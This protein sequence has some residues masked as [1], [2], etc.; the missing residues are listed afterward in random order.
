MYLRAACILPVHFR[1]KLDGFVEEQSQS[2]AHMTQ[3]Q[4]FTVDVAVYGFLSGALS[5]TAETIFKRTGMLP[6]TLG[7][8]ASPGP[9][10]R[11]AGARCAPPFAAAR[12]LL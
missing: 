8:L 11:R 7:G 4:V 12:L 5:G 6:L 1:L 2:T 9:L 10:G 3:E